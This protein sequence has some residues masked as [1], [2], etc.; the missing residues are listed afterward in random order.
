MNENENQNE[1][2]MKKKYLKPEASVEAMELE[3][4]IA[5]SRSDA[6]AD[7]SDGLSRDFDMEDM[8]EKVVF[9]DMIDL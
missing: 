3:Q 1:K 2:V 8:A 9:F 5:L 7:S 4:F 6:P